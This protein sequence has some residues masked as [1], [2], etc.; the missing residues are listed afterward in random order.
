M[1]IAAGR[2]EDL[3]AAVRQGPRVLPHGA[4]TKPALSTPPDDVVALDVSGLS[5][6]LEYDPAELT[7]T[8]LA[9]TPVAEVSAI[10]AEHGQYLPFDPPLSHA[11]ATLGGVVAAGTS[12][13]NALRHGGVRDFVIGVRFIDGTGRVIGSGGKVVKN[14]AGFDLSKLM[15][16]SLGRLGV[17]VQVS[18]KVF[19]R[20]E[21]TSTLRVDL[22]S[23]DAALRA[24]TALRRGPVDLDALDLEP[25]GRLILRLGGAGETLPARATRLASLLDA[26]AERLE[27]EADAQ[28]WRHAAE[29]DW[30]PTG[31][32][33]VK[34]GLTPGR[35]PGLQAALAPS[36]ARVRYSLAGNLGWLAWPEDRDLAELDAA[37]RSLELAGV[38]LTGSSGR[39]LI[40]RIGGGAFATRVRSAL[41]PHARFLEV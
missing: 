25:P 18:F 35:I 16:G 11:G 36:G 12:G 21:A 22:G 2:V 19:P 5:G 26:P 37:L 13:P 32:A 6:I 15:V 20:P 4:G 1:S 31:S 9:G 8:A 27:D 39:G 3:Q 14:A 41:D 40:G 7:F 23:T 10:L 29:L 17:L 28:E 34:V 24:L 38:V 33:L 30:V